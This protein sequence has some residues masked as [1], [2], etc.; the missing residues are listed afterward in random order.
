MAYFANSPKCGKVDKDDW[1]GAGRG[2]WQGFRV[3]MLKPDVV[4]VELW[5]APN[6]GHSVTHCPH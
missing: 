5:G 2:G 1:W 6:E 4:D 3:E